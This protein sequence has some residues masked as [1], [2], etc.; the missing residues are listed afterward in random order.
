MKK[1]KFFIVATIVAATIGFT[2]CSSSKAVS[3]TSKALN[4]EEVKVEMTKSEEL[5]FDKPAIRDFGEGTNFNLSFAKTFAEGQ[6]RA[7]FQ[8]KVEALVQT[9]SEEAFTGYQQ[10]STNGAESSIV[11]DQDIKSGAFAKQVA[12]GILKNTATIHADKFKKADGQYHVYVCIEYQGEVGEMVE[13]MVE[14][15]KKRVPQQV[16]DDERVKIQFEIE[17]FKKKLENDFNR[18]REE[19]KR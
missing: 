17:Q 3:E 12:E 19:Q 15:A 10:A 2:A 7:A 9:A 14:A 8:R 1:N 18:L 11:S 4:Q 5:A 13:K 6:A 16:S